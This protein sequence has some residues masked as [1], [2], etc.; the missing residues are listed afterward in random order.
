MYNYKSTLCFT[1]EVVIQLV[2]IWERLSHCYC[3]DLWWTL[4]VLHQK[5]TGWKEFAE[6]KSAL[7]HLLQIRRQQTSDISFFPFIFPMSMSLNKGGIFLVVSFT[8]NPILNLLIPHFIERV[9]VYSG[10][11]CES[12]T[13]FYD[14]SW[15]NTDLAQCETKKKKKICVPAVFIRRLLNV[16]MFTACDAQRFHSV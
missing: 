5:L 16:H 10:I 3:G 15:I 13:Y 6:W 14:A 1:S 12:A 9:Q 8:V 7:S 4:T 2:K 11:S